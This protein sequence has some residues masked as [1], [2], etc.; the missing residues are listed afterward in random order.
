MK[1]LLMKTFFI[2]FM[3]MNELEIAKKIVETLKDLQLNDDVV[4]TEVDNTQSP[5][6][7]PGSDNHRPQ[8][9]FAVLDKGTTPWD[10]N[11]IM[12]IYADIYSFLVRTHG[13]ECL[14]TP[15]SMRKYYLAPV[16]GVKVDILDPHTNIMSAYV[17]HQFQFVLTVHHVEQIGIRQNYYTL[18]S[19]SVEEVNKI[20]TSL[21]AQR[22]VPKRLEHTLKLIKK[23]TVDMKVSSNNPVDNELGTIKVKYE[24]PDD[25]EITV[26]SVPA[27]DYKIN[28]YVNLP[29]NSIH[30]E[31]LT[32]NKMHDQD[33]IRTVYYGLERILKHHKLK[34]G[35][36]SFVVCSKIDI[37]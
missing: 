21:V 18:T 27:M 34:F 12:N 16:E 22:N 5:Y 4:L 13:P 1:G 31:I 10:I 9:H 32:P 19:H 33:R 8:V 15:I 20:I 7:K 11:H 29:E 3:Y 17:R 28:G 30:V 35:Q 26:R 6:Y 14:D 36:E 24:F 37:K 2:I 23:G 25:T